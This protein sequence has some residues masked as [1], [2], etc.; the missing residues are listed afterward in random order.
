MPLVFVF[1]GNPFGKVIF[2]GVLGSS[3]SVALALLLRL[4]TAR[5]QA[6]WILVVPTYVAV[7]VGVPVLGATALSDLFVAVGNSLVFFTI[8]PPAFGMYLGFIVSFPTL[9]WSRDRALASGQRE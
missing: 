1:S 8:L 4:P 7:L 5:R 9:A 3:V 6:Y 2:W